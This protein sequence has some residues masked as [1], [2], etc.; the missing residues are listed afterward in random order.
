MIYN[1]ELF[2]PISCDKI[3]FE[4]WE[5]KPPLLGRTDTLGTPSSLSVIKTEDTPTLMGLTDKDGVPLSLR[6]THAEA[7]H[8]WEAERNPASFTGI[9]CTFS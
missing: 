3:G 5:A 9:F 4:E 2:S 8:D 7:K 6:L 1:G